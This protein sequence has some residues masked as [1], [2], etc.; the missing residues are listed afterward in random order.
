MDNQD[1]E[2]TLN[3][4]SRITTEKESNSKSN[5]ELIA[6][7]ENDN[8]G[9]REGEILFAVPEPQEVKSRPLSESEKQHYTQIDIEAERNRLAILA[10]QITFNKQ[11]FM[12][13]D[14][15]R[16]F[17]MY[18]LVGLA[19]ILALLLLGQITSAL[20]QFTTLPIWSQWIIGPLLVLVVLVIVYLIVRLMMLFFKLQRN[21]QVN[22]NGIKAL[23]E[24]EALRMLSK[25]KTEE[26]LHKLKLYLK[27]FPIENESQFLSLG[28][29]EDEYSHLTDTHRKLLEERPEY[30]TPN[31]WLS[32]F[33]V[34]FQAELNKIAMRRAKG[35]ATKTAI[36]TAISPLPI[37][38]MTIA[39][40]L[41]L[42]MVRDMMVLYNLRMSYGGAGQILLRA[43]GQAYIAGELQD[44]SEGLAD[45]LGDMITEQTGQ[46][47]A[48]AIAK[49]IGSKVAEGTANG[50]MIYRLGK[51]T[52]KLLQPSY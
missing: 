38:D 52:S 19:A 9:Y 44:L 11:G 26:A 46:V 45:A 21:E 3:D 6:N 20:V 31:K 4:P 36:K 25:E 14:G 24:R 42:A 13:P 23:N 2:F 41:G 43:I 30:E 7:N 12:L 51:S 50:L 1:N 5:P 47:A 27:K 37:L 48:G 29:T 10:S 33:Q 49:V 17:G 40:A 32:D 28:F 39:L 18:A 35:Y 15:L 34:G 8:T 22:L 16:K